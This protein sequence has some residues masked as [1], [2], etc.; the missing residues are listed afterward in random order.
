MTDVDHVSKQTRRMPLWLLVAISALA[1]LFYAFAAW[2][3]VANLIQALA[4]FGSL[5]A[6]GWFVWIF[7]ALF[8]L[9]VWAA[10]FALGYRRRPHELAL[11]M[12]TGLCLVSVFWLNV[13]AYT[14]LQTTSFLG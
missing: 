4:L 13:V 7:A 1:G 11:I 2:S 12:L 8:P 6:L 10:A 3:A 14:G 5:N 9:I